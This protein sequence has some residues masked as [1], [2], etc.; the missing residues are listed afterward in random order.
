MGSIVS[1]S[2][3]S[4]KKLVIAVKGMSLWYGIS[5]IQMCPSFMSAL[6]ILTI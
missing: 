3:R 2:I 5:A 4:G 1:R 6:G